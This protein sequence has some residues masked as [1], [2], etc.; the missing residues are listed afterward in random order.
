MGGTLSGAKQNDFG[1]RFDCI[2][3]C[4][5]MFCFDLLLNFCFLLSFMTMRKP[6]HAPSWDLPMLAIFAVLRQ[7]ALQWLLRAKVDTMLSP[8][9]N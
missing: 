8:Q 1:D 9:A 6:S 3:H 7:V 2:L 4:E 5:V